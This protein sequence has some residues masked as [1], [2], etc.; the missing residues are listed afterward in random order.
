MNSC[1]R[2]YVY[3]FVKYFCLLVVFVE[4]TRRNMAGSKSDKDAWP[5]YTI[6]PFARPFFDAISSVQL[7]VVKDTQVF[8]SLNPL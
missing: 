5:K 1:N 7:P 8:F 2:F 6:Q 3:G 4:R